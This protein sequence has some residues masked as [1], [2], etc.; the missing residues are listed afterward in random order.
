MFETNRSENHLKNLKEKLIERHYPEEL[1][2]RKFEKAKKKDG[3][4]LSFRNRKTAKKD[5]KIR[6]FFTQNESPSSVDERC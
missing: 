3:K 5:E 1:I 6:L 4:S 2:D